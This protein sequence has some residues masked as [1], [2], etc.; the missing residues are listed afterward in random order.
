MTTKS[1]A[2]ARRRARDAEAIGDFLAGAICASLLALVMLAWCGCGFRVDGQGGSELAPDAG[3]P[4]IDATPVFATLGQT[5]D[6]VIAPTVGARCDLASPAGATGDQA[7]YRVFPLAHAFALTDV[8]LRLAHAH[9]ARGVQ[10]KIGRFAG[11]A[12]GP[13][14]VMGG[15][16][17]LVTSTI[18]MPDAGGPLDVNIGGTTPAA[19]LAAGDNLI[20]GVVA[21]SYQATGGD[22]CLGFTIAPES[23]PSYFA[24]STC[25]VAAST[26][27][28][29]MGALGHLVL[30]VSGWSMP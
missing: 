23:A 30:E 25:G 8:H 9:N 2:G 13:S 17:W 14:L 19:T 1:N 10:V 5:A 26:S 24:S 7:W 22:L 20:I 16:T 4:A 6:G 12:G 21:P 18:D 11:T 3:M 29:A 27:T 28:E 15:A